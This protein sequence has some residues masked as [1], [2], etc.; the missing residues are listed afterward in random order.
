MLRT[1][2]T[3]IFRTFV[4][5]DFKNDFISERAANPSTDKEKDGL[6]TKQF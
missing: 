3:V 1:T 5:L 4:Y 2:R 6:Y